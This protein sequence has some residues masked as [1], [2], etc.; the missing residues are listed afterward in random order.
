MAQR[1]ELAEL[2]RK[3]G[4]EGKDKKTGGIGKVAE[5]KL[6]AKVAL[7]KQYDK[8]IED[9]ETNKDKYKCFS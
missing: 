4:E 7:I 8:L 3:P 9:Y 6:E 5:G 1:K 2:K